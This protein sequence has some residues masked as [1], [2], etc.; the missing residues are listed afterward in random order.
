[1][2]LGWKHSGIVKFCLHKATTFPMRSLQKAVIILLS[3]GLEPCSQFSGKQC[4]YKAWPGTFPNMKPAPSP[5][6]PSSSTPPNEKACE[7]KKSESEHEAQLEQIQVGKKLERQEERWPWPSPSTIPLQ[8]HERK[9][10]TKRIHHVQPC[11]RLNMD[12]FMP[13]SQ[14]Q[15]D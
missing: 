2:I 14:A 15:P 6:L 4:E 9:N 8:S 3:T 12:Q 1:M 5:A 13:D 7:R 11:P 10:L